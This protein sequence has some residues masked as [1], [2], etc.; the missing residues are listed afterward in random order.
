MNGIG[1]RGVAYSS[2][3]KTL[4]RRHYC[5]SCDAP[6]K[7][8]SR[9]ITDEFQTEFDV[10]EYAIFYCPRCGACI[11]VSMQISYEDVAL[12]AIKVEKYFKKKMGKDILITRHLYIPH[13]YADIIYNGERGS[14]YLKIQGDVSEELTYDVKIKNDKFVV[15]KRK[16][17]KFIKKH[18]K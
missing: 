14:M 17:I 15:R 5:Y 1:S 11:E 10:V 18:L 16:L 6:V 9:D 13:N 8:S 3:I 12:L 7:L 2:P 4:F